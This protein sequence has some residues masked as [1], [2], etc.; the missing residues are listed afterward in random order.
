MIANLFRFFLIAITLC[1]TTTVQAATYYVGPRG[2][3]TRSTSQASNRS[4]PWRSI[5]RALDF[6]VAG[7]VIVVLNGTYN[8]QARFRRGGT[9]G[10]Q[11]VLRAENRERARVVGSISGTNISF[12]TV[13]GFD[14]S[15]YQRTGLTKGI[16]FQRCHHITVRSN[17]VREC[18][19]GGI[20]FDQSDWILVE[21]NK[22]HENAFWDANQ[23]SGISIYQPQYRGSDSAYWGIQVRNNTSYRNW[24]FVD[25]AD[26]GRP[27]DGNGIVLD[28]FYNSQQPSGNGQRYNRP[29]VVEN[30]LCFGNGGQGIHSYLSQNIDI[31]NN[32]CVNNVGSFDFGAEITI[33][34]SNRVYAYNN[35][36]S[37]SRG[38]RAILQFGSSDFW[39]G[40][41]VISGLTDG[42]N[43][44]SGNNI[45]A[46]PQFVPGSVELQANSPGV[47]QGLDVGFHYFQDLWGRDRVIGN[48]DIGA[49]ERQN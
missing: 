16:S 36:V 10:N 39:V 34:D 44:N 11:I 31:R 5:Q 38:K 6:A 2:D 24:N 22:V 43:R 4:T 7:D 12:V 13:E 45:N 18:S 1:V 27:T 23:H 17:R 21:W 33:G 20:A 42:I 26:F 35:I 30:N 28:D 46:A 41:S 47:D 37:A 25:N 3:N 19:G 15:N 8:E 29:V 49:M 48:I 32:T 9:S 40:Y 14:V